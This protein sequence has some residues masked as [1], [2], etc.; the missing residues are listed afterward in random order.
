[1]ENLCAQLENKHSHTL[2]ER[3]AAHYR[4]HSN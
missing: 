2:E 4:T 3:T 1:M